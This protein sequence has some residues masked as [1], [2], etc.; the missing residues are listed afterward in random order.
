MFN[1][2]L[3]ICYDDYNGFDVLEKLTSKPEI[4]WLL[5]NITTLHI[6]G[7]NGRSRLWSAAGYHRILPFLGGATEVHVHFDA[8]RH[9]YT[10][11]DSDCYTS[12]WAALLADGY[13]AEFDAGHKD[14]EFSYAAGLLKVDGLAK[15]LEENG[16]GDCEVYL[17]THVTW[18]A[19]YRV[20]W[21][22]MVMF[23][24]TSEGLEAVERRG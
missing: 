9:C 16:R 12:E 6:D 14:H 24:V 11:R 22:Q 19:H 2:S 20:G 13:K 1:G 3:T 17:S 23:R 7:F 5:E 21:Q 8:T 10:D 18:L 4:A 15:L